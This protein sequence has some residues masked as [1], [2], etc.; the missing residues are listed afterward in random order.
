MVDEGIIY[1]KFRNLDRATI[2]MIASLKA[3]VSK[4]TR[5]IARLGREMMG[6][7]GILSDNYCMKALVDA[8]VIYTY[9]GTYDINALITARE[10]TGISAFKS[11]SKDI[12]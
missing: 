3:W 11:N 1:L 12:K 5:D 4:E 8:E 6:G 10:L 7:N 2:G 9:E